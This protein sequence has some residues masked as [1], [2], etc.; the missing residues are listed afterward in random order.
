MTLHDHAE[1]L[2]ALPFRTILSVRAATKP[3]SAAG[4]N[5]EQKK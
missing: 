2:R 3:L 1:R 4:W 5:V